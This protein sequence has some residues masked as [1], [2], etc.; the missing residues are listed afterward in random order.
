LLDVFE[1]RVVVQSCN[2]GCVGMVVGRSKMN[3]PTILP[4][5]FS[6]KKVRHDEYGLELFSTA[7]CTDTHTMIV[8]QER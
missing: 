8:T 6:G 5:F 1:A 3:V 7:A 2:S 4:P